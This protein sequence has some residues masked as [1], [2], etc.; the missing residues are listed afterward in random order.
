MAAA[1]AD[2]GDD[3]MFVIEEM[4]PMP[5]MMPLMMPPTLGALG[6]LGGDYIEETIR[7]D[8]TQ[9]KKEVHHGDGYETVTITETGG[10]Q[11]EMPGEMMGQLM[12]EMTGVPMMPIHQISDEAFEIPPLKEL[13]T[14]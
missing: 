2:D 1:E 5:M 13:V 6:G 10:H 12:S 11:G 4:Q 7:S 3:E 14:L 9:I 8:G